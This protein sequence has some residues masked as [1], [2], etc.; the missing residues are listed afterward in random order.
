VPS[1]SEI[2]RCV[3]NPCVNLP[4]LSDISDSEP[5]QLICSHHFRISP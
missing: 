5:G 4:I 2:R 1:G 3:K